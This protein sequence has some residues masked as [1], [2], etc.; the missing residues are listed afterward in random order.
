MLN[1]RKTNEVIKYKKT[2][3]SHDYTLLILVA[4]EERTGAALT[5]LHWG[6]IHKSMAL[7]SYELIATLEYVYAHKGSHHSEK[8]AQKLV[9]HVSMNDGNTLDAVGGPDSS[10]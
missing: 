7:S 10:G 4:K 2:A 3:T 1:L 8:L 5:P 6:S 9:W